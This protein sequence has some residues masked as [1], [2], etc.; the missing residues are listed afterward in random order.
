MLL[1]L[2]EDPGRLLQVTR[3]PLELLVLRGE[4]AAQTRQRIRPHGRRGRL[5]R[6]GRGL[7][8]E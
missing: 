1:L 6:G 4:D 7:P 5:L 2:S 8:G 3:E